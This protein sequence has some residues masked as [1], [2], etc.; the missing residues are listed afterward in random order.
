MTTALGER[1]RELRDGWMTQADL[2]TAADVSLSLVR[3]LEQGQRHTASVATL[4]RIARAL[5]VDL[6]EVFG[7]EA[8]P[9]A[10]PDAGVATVGSRSVR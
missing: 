8:M 3:K 7:R 2:A 9:D 1:I 10:G 4:H 5:D 6:G